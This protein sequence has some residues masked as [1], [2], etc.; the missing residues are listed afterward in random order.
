MASVLSLQLPLQ[1]EIGERLISDV[2]AL[3]RLW[4]AGNLSDQQLAFMQT[5]LVSSRGLLELLTSAPTIFV[6]RSCICA[7]QYTYTEVCIRSR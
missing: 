6:Q 2:R 1:Q 5:N 7:R 3:E 4:Q